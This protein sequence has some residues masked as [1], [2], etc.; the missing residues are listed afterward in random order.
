MERVQTFA[1]GYEKANGGPCEMFKNFVE[2]LRN[3]GKEDEE[4][5]EE[6]NE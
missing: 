6:E 4:Q 2:S 5:E 1:P 3:E